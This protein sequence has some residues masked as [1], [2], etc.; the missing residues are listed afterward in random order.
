MLTQTADAFA[1]V[2]A[3]LSWFVDTY[4][5]LA[6]WKAGVDRLTTFSEAM[7]KAKQEAASTA[8]EESTGK[9]GELTVR[10][11]EVRLPNG[12][13][14]LENVDLT[15]HQGQSLLISGPS[16]SGKT[17]L[18]RVLAGL[19][20]YGRG[21]VGLPPDARVLFLPQKPYLPIG[22]LKEVLSYPDAPVA[23]GDEAYREALQA[24]GLGHL[25]PRLDEATNW[26][27]VLS[28]GEQQRLAF[29]R[30]LLY[31]PNWLF[32]DE[33]TSALDDPAEQRMYEL[34]AE[35]LPGATLISIAH[36]PAAVAMHQHKVTIDPARHR[37]ES[38]AVA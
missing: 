9:A 18:F 13:V 31:R 17:T 36:R 4:Q 26:S 15:V 19:W 2:Q 35:R 12:S 28:G 20:P 8:F 5:R 34:I 16:G 6:E 14:L 21:R 37:I 38:S 22:T 1:Q 7:V 27:L 23:H 30:A 29:A 32:L 10:D 33:A 3:A 11:A 24:C 25:L